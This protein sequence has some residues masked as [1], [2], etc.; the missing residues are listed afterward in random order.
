LG[1]LELLLAAQPGQAAEGSAAARP[2]AGGVAG[3][4]PMQL[5]LLHSP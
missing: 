4:Q 5:V 1:T 2:G 3:W